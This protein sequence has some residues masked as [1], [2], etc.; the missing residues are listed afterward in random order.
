[1]TL[2]PGPHDVAR[3]AAG[4]VADLAGRLSMMTAR[5]DAAEGEIIRLRGLIVQ[6]EVCLGEGLEELAVDLPGMVEHD[7]GH[8]MDYDLP[9]AEAAFDDLKRLLAE[10]LTRTVDERPPHLRPEPRHP[11]PEAGGGG[12]QRV[13]PPPPEARAAGAVRESGSETPLRTP[14]R[15]HPTQRRSP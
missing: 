1:M 12:G 15:A 8:P 11:R 7:T 5:L 2:P 3:R 6:A 14:Q 10:L 4:V 13:L 9:S